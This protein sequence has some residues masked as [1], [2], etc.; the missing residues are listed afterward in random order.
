LEF[1]H[2]FSL[3]HGGCRKIR[4]TT[5]Y[6]V[7][8]HCESAPLGGFRTLR[9]PAA[10]KA[11]FE[12]LAAKDPTHLGWQDSLARAA[13]RIGD[14]LVKQRKF[15]EAVAAYNDC[16]VAAT[17]IVTKDP[18][19]L[20]YQRELSVCHARLAHAYEV[21][22][23]LDEALAA[24]RESRAIM[25]VLG[26]KDPSNDWW[27][28]DLAVVEQDIGNVLVAMGGTEEAID[29]DRE[30]LAIRRMLAAKQPGNTNWQSDLGWIL[31]NLALALHKKG[32]LADA[33]ASARASSAVFAQLVKTHPGDTE[34]QR[35]LDAAINR[36]GA[37]AYDFL[38]TKDFA[39]A[40]SLAD[41]TIALAPARVW[42]Y[43][44]RAY[45]LMFLDR[46]DEARAIFIRYRGEKTQGNM[47]W[48]AF[49]LKDFAELR[50]A[51]LTQPL[52]DEIE[53]L[54]GEQPQEQVKN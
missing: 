36:I 52:M 18:Q 13:Y 40:L 26:K 49:V 23:K 28:R 14:V 5:P 7:S 50:K 43:T 34:G 12:T 33:L 10:I 1:L 27:Q 19:N 30:S 37:I 48:E 2:L 17:A 4:K 20:D 41:E 21:Q 39:T 22:G 29:I 25:Q 35:G 44:N 15:A 38:R 24:Y 3:S 8:L 53:K 46:T 16:L 42:L 47:S 31:G 45:A 11:I 51:G 54:F 9:T 32:N 6:K